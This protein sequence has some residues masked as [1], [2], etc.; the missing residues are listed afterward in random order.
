MPEAISDQLTLQMKGL[1]VEAANAACPNPI[2]IMIDCAVQVQPI[3]FNAHDTQTPGAHRYNF[4]GKQ[5]TKILN[6]I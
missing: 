5:N 6:V 2:R 1:D 4:R 3:S